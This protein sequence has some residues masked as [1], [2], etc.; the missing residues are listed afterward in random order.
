[1]QTFL[2]YDNFV[3]TARV[4][5]DKRLG[6]QR[7]EAKQIHNALTGVTGGWRNHPATRMWE[8]YEGA[9]AMYGYVICLEWRARGFNDTLLPWFGERWPPNHRTHMPPWMGLQVFHKAHRSNLVRKDPE[10]YRQFWPS[11][12]DDLPYFWPI[13]KAVA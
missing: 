10:Y 9:L 7:V 1:M 5:D 3:R 6:K 11:I 8:G 12:E 2:P 13:G 4:L